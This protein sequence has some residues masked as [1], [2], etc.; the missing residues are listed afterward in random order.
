MRCGEIAL[1]LRI[2][3]RHSAK[4]FNIAQH[5]ISGSKIFH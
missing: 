3:L 2:R 1:F 4:L 5:G